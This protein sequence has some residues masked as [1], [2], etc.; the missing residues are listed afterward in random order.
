MAEK[1]LER[2]LQ[3]IE[4][5]NLIVELIN[6]NQSLRKEL[7]NCKNHQDVINL[8]RKWGFTIDKRWGEE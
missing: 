1:D 3:K 6:K 8:T 5:L 2:F 7:S 4:H